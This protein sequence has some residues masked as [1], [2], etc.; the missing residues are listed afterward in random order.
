MKFIFTMLSTLLIFSSWAFAAPVRGAIAGSCMMQAD[1]SMQ[2]VQNGNVDSTGK[3]LTNTP[4]GY[5]GA[6]YPVTYC[7]SSGSNLSVRCADGWKP[8]MQSISQMDCRTSNSADM[9]WTYFISYSC[10]KL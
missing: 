2:V 5:G 6:T 7:P 1:H 4:E 10:A 9:C 8:V 3:R